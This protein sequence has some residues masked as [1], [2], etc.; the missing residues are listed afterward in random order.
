MS[1]KLKPDQLAKVSELAKALEG[2]GIQQMGE[3]G[4]ILVKIAE[5]VEVARH[6]EQAG[7][8][9]LLTNSQPE[10]ADADTMMFRVVTA[11]RSIKDIISNVVLD[12]ENTALERL[13]IEPTLR[14][15]QMNMI[16]FD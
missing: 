15:V 7:F 2:R 9:M 6:L 5:Q 1:G 13:K 3:D 10:A 8:G 12:E 16:A 11:P 4:E 14:S